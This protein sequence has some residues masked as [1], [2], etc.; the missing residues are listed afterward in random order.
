MTRTTLE[1]A[2]KHEACQHLAALPAT[3]SG[4]V[5]EGAGG[6]WLCSFRRDY[7]NRPRRRKAVAA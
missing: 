5:T 6:K 4:S 7:P 1:F 3:Y 2:T